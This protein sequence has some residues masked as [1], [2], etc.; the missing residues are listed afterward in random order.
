[1]LVF[2]DALLIDYATLLCRN[3]FNKTFWKM[4]GF[5]C[6]FG[7]GQLGPVV[8]FENCPCFAYTRPGFQTRRWSLKP[9]PKPKPKPWLRKMLQKGHKNAQTTVT[10][11]Q[12]KHYMILIATGSH[13][14]SNYFNYDWL[15][16]VWTYIVLCLMFA[17]ISISLKLCRT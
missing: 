5:G 4:T 6:G 9:N 12:F 1:M 10:G 7:S 15:G 11:T 8:V 16:A 14:R 17:F 13:S 2:Q 3:L